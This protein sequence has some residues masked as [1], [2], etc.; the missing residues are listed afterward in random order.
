M[1]I[2]F[3]S[4]RDS[5]II[6]LLKDGISPKEVME[7]ADHSSLEVT[8]KYVKKARVEASEVIKRKS[9]GF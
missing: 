9:S 7:L 2:Q 6:Q 1:A 3:Y 4:L 8:N 5:G